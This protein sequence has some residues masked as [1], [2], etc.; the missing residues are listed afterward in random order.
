MI[1]PK[2]WIFCLM[3][4]LERYLLCAHLIESNFYCTYS[5]KM[6]G[7]M[8]STKC[9]IIDFSFFFIIYFR[10]FRTFFMSTTS[11]PTLAYNATRKKIGSWN[12][13][14]CILWHKQN[15]TKKS[16]T[17]KDDKVII[18]M[19]FSEINVNQRKFQHIVYFVNKRKQ[20]TV[21]IDFF[22]FNAEPYIM[23]F[24]CF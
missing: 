17:T 13:S 2:K 5:I 7:M 24:G 16:T 4:R 8:G 10:N 14:N 1:Q 21:T 9:F 22:F 3:K 19:K 18:N 20:Q 11:I 12:F 6:T 23:H 15:E